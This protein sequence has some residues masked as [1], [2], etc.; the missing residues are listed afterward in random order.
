MEDN[1]PVPYRSVWT[2]LYDVS[3]THGFVDA[4]GVRTRYIQAGPKDAPTVIFLH[5]T[6]ASWESCCANIRPHAKHFNTIA[7]DM[8]GAGFSDKPDQLFTLDV[9]VEHLRAFM[10]ALG[11]ERA[12]VAGVSLGSFVAAKFAQRYPRRTDKITMI[13]AVG[14]PFR[15]NP[16]MSEDEQGQYLLDA[17]RKRRQQQVENPTWEAM[18]ALL[19]RLISKP[20]D[21]VDDLIAIRQAVYRQ[22]AMR[23]A[24]E[25]IMDLYAPAVFNKDAITPEEWRRIEVP[26]LIT[27]SVDAKDWFYETAVEINGLLP[28]S[29]LLECPGASHWPQWECPDH[30]NEANIA[31]LLER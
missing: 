13:S 23:A 28:D 2:N 6:A 21:C 14:L 27:L 7:L 29:R 10:D 16:D 20:E 30:F 1:H 4:G 31:F 11:I 19:T 12:S 25:N 5:G 17:A 8:V 26:V 15:H 24:M 3:F 18:R 9:Y 22:P